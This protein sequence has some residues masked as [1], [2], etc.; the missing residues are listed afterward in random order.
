MGS[1]EFL[2]GTAA[3]RL[4]L[5]PLV[6]RPVSRLCGRFLDTGLSRPL[7][8]PF[9]RHTGIDTADYDLSTVRCFNDFFCSFLCNLFCCISCSSAVCVL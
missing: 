4:V 5:R 1:L 9:I 8:R 7:I 6:S 2:Y 3:G